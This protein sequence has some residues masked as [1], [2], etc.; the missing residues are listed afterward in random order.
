MASFLNTMFVPSR[1]A[2]HF[3][4]LRKAPLAPVA[5]LEPSHSCIDLL[6][7]AQLQQATI[8]DAL[9]TAETSSTESLRGCLASITPPSRRPKFSQSPRSSPALIGWITG[10]A[11]ARPSPLQDSLVPS[12]RKLR[13]A[14]CKRG[15]H[16]HSPRRSEL[17]T[18]CSGRNS[19]ARGQFRPQ[20]TQKGTS[21]WQL[22]QFAEATLGSGSLRKAVKLPEG[23]DVNE[24][25]AVNGKQYIINPA[26]AHLGKRR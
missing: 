24:W 2:P 17:I 21:S 10:D 19:R 1:P 6:H 9:Q 12:P 14:D 3:P 8:R 13:T 20:K 22:R 5:S 4:H 16:I 7:A 18:P 23:E 25:L 11:P 15:P 26:P